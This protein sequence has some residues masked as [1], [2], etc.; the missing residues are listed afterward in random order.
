MIFRQL[1]LK[2]RLKTIDCLRNLNGSIKVTQPTNQ[3]EA[4]S[5]AFSTVTV[6]FGNDS[7]PL[8]KANHLLVEHT[9][10]RNVVVAELF[11]F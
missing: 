2:G 5:K 11:R 1:L 9:P 10:A 3:A 7:E 8:G 4:E 6:M